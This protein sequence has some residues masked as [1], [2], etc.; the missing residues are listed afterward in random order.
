MNTRSGER[1]RAIALVMALFFAGTLPARPV[2]VLICVADDQS[3]PHASAYG[4]TWVATPAFDRVAREGLLFTRAYTP[5]AKCGPSRASL[6]TGRLSWQLGAA[7]N[8]G[9]FYPAG[10]RTFME[11]L[12]AAG[13]LVGF[14]GKGWAPGDPGKVDGVSRQLT[15]REFNAH[16]LEHPVPACSPLDYAANFADFLRAREGRPFCFWFGANEPHRPYAVGSGVRAG[17]DRGSVEV[18]PYWPDVPAVRDDL[19]DYAAEIGHFDTQLGRVLALLAEAGELENTI[20]IVT[21]DNGMP[22]PRVKGTTYDASLHLPLAIR[23][24]QGVRQPGRV[25]EDYVSLIDLA[26][27]VLE[28]AGIPAGTSGMA[29]I[30][31]R[32]LAPILSAQPDQAGARDHL[33]FGQERHDLGRPNDQGYPV[34]GLLQD[35]YLYARNFA[36]DRWPMGDPITGYLNT[37]GGAT[38]TVIL[39]DNRRGVNHWIW[40]LNFGRRPAEELYHL[41]TDPHCLRNLANKPAEAAR[42]AAMWDRL[43]AE[44]QRQDDPRM[45]GRGEEFDRYPYSTLLRDYYARFLRGERPPVPWVEQTD[46]ENPSFDPECPRSGPTTPNP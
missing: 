3:Y 37:D 40:E 13:Y 33:V 38:K 5:N 6:L 4:C 21:S 44:L 41:A 15:G 32:S 8:H 30:E 10:F 14:T 16:R 31:G 29:A 26:P 19:L 23:W 46:F 7:A 20:V 24:P 11:A 27:T 12:D 25:I 2:N 34:R 28:A 35:G 1:R 22:F 18:P 42:L 9:A 43:S 39:G 17:G 45:V 36:S